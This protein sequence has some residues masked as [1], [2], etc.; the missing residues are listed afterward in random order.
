MNHEKTPDLS[1]T[2]AGVKFKNPILPGSAETA[3]DIETVKKMVA[4]GVGGVVTKSFSSMKEPTRRLR[5]YNFALSSKR[6]GRGYGETGSFYTYA[7]PHPRDIELTIEE[8]IPEMAKICHANG[9]PLVVSY[10]GEIANIQDWVQLGKRIELAGADMVEL[11]FSCPQARKP[12][13]EDPDLSVN[14]IKAV[15]SKLNIPVGPKVSPSIEPIESLA[16]RWQNAGAAFLVAHNGLAGLVIDVEKE[17]PFGGPAYGAI[18]TKTILPYSLARVARM[19]KVVNIPVIGVSGVWNV[20][21]TLQYMLAGSPA[22]QICSAA[23]FKGFDVYRQTVDDLSSWMQKKGYTK[24]DDFVGKCL[25]MI[26]SG[27]ELKEQADFLFTE[28]PNTPYAPVVDREKC[29]YCKICSTVCHY[30]VYEV[31]KAI[32]KIEIDGDKCWSCGW[33]IAQCPKEALTLVD[34]ANGEMIWDGTG[35]AV[36]FKRI[37]EK[38]SADDVLRVIR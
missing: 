20:T 3:E 10:F 6:F 12:F 5:P 9:V 28:P 24:V 29:S 8:Q 1:V 25:P 34:K 36:P 2:I 32:S 14:I 17:E 15:A 30:G 7:C 19:A 11:Q 18:L 33:C 27:D 23:Y 26:M 38:R 22:V 37:L 16:I 4:S 35:M 13:E 21:D 31:D